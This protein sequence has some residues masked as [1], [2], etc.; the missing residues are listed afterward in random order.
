MR[1]LQPSRICLRPILRP[2]L[3]MRRQ[4]LGNARYRSFHYQPNQGPYYQKPK[5]RIV[6]DMVLGSV[7]TFSTYFAYTFYQYQKALKHLETETEATKK[8][9]EGFA[10]QFAQAREAKDHDKLRE[11]SFSFNRALLSQHGDAI[12]EA[13]PLPPY[14][15]DDELHGKEMIP[16]EDT[17]MFVEKDE[18]HFITVVQITVNVEFEE[19]NGEWKNTDALVDPA[20]NKLGELL[21][22]FEYQ[23]EFWR[24]QEKL[25]G[26]QLFVVF[27]LR[28]KFWT[29]QYS[30][31]PWNSVGVTSFN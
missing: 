3:G 19:V 13:G 24:K 21:T 1:G 12:F 10:Q 2:S 8:V 17:L 5:S 31:D 22:R 6:R 29:F 11:A 15:E 7:L 28:D 16:T 27:A 20:D 26:G 14:P 25:R 18:D 9:Y 4:F 23:V 30:Y